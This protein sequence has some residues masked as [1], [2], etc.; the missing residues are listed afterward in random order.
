VCARP[1]PERN[2]TKNDVRKNLAQSKQIGISWSIEEVQEVRLDLT[3]AQAWEVFQLVERCHD[4]NFGIT[5]GT[6]D[7]AA[8]TSLGDRADPTT[9][10]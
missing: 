9:N 1:L 5:L 6:L 7:M 10:K 2:Q 8:R 3:N 4:A